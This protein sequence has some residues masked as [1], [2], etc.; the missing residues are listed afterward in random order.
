[1]KKIMIIFFLILI[2]IIFTNKKT[3]IVEDYDE[4]DVPKK[5]W[6]YWEDEN[7]IPKTVKMCMKGWKKFNPNYEIT[8]IT[9]KNFDKYVKIPK[10]ISTHPNFND[11]PQRFSDLIRLW[12][13]A[14]QG[15]VWIDSSTILKRSL[16]EMFTKNNVEYY[17]YY[18]DSF[19]KNKNFPVIESWFFACTK[20]SKFVKL[21][22]DEFTK[23]SKYSSV[24]K[25]INSRK[26]MNV[27]FQNI[28]IPNYLAIHISAQKILQYNKYS[29]KTL[30]L[31]KAEDGP[32]KYLVDANWDAKN[33]FK[34]ACN[35][36]NYNTFMKLRGNERAVMEEN[37]EEFSDEKCGWFN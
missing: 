7:N 18:I 3:C 5:I 14:K 12:I 21:W 28:S 10:S 6:T 37:S 29:L 13:L 11:T 23:I 2:L 31:E 16:D 17:G 24:E 22:R 8:L 20:N 4:D 35:N 34:L 25:Y 27:D 33:A 15:G 1:M 30:I 19:T 32:F 9:K 36:S 26:D